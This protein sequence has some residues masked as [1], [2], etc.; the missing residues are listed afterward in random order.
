MSIS[1]AAARE[2]H[3]RRAYRRC[4]HIHGCT[5]LK[6]E[7]DY[8]LYMYIHISH[9]SYGQ[10][11]IHTWTPAQV[12]ADA[13]VHTPTRACAHR[14]CRGA[15]RPRWH[16]TPAER[17]C[18]MA[19]AG[20]GA[21]RGQRR[22]TRGVPRADV[23]VERRCVVK[24]LPKPTESARTCGADRCAENHVRTRGRICG[25]GTHRWYVHL[26]S[27]TH[28]YRQMHVMWVC[29]QNTYVWFHR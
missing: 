10:L 25:A 1:S 19:P 28:G 26:C 27:Y 2:H 13:C 23:R 21:Y 9:L 4:I 15:Q 14:R 5:R 11:K 16:R 18:R 22:D 29:I 6:H 24:R 8:K 3:R 12:S 20:S 17:V 7:P